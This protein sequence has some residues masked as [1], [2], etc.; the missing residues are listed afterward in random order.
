MTT[1]PS[2]PGEALAALKGAL[3][4]HLAAAQRRAGEQDEAVQHAYT[5]LR[6]AAAAYEESLYDAHDEVLPWELPALEGLAGGPAEPDEVTRVGLLLRRDY[7]LA[8]PDALLAAG[9]A[10][11]RQ[12]NPA[13]TGDEAAARIGDG[14]AALVQLLHANGIDGFDGRAPSAGLAALGGTVWLVA[15]DEDDTSM[16][17]EEPYAVAAE[18]ELIYRLDEAS[19]GDPDQAVPGPPTG[20][21]SG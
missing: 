18:E 7:A 5:R 12:A 17:G 20:Q 19:H 10:A 21:R 8:D 2:G 16:G 15:V 9:R 6:E 11:F 3:E 1:T 14:G 4:A 13:A